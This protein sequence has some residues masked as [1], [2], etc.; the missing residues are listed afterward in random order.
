MAEL[1]AAAE[2]GKAVMQSMMMDA[3]KQSTPNGLMPLMG[4]MLPKPVTGLI[5]T[6][7]AKNDP[8]KDPYK[9][10]Q[11]IVYDADGNLKK[12]EPNPYAGLLSAMSAPPEKD[13]NLIDKA[14][15]APMPPVT[16]VT[17]TSQVD[18]SKKLRQQAFGVY[19]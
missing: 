13:L 16:R 19:R 9:P 15:P 8:T 12:P 3:V 1:L 18:P 6:V 2:G 5:D 10:E 14:P 7:M 4:D 17:Q 11:P